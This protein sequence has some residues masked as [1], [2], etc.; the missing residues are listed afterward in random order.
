MESKKVYAVALAGG[1]GAALWPLS[2]KRKPK[3]LLHCGHDTSLLEQTI[4]RISPLVPVENRW[5]ITTE[6]QLDSIEPVISSLVGNIIIEP[7]GRDTAAA[8]IHAA[9]VLEQHDSNTVVIFL[10]TDHY[11]PQVPKFLDFLSH[12]IDFAMHHEKITFLGLP[13]AYPAPEYGYI[14]YD[15]DSVDYP[16]RVTF[17]H[18]KPSMGLCAEYVAQGLLWNSGIVVSQ[19]RLFLEECKEV[20]PDIFEAVYAYLYQDGDY[21]GIPKLSAQKAFFEK[22]TESSVLPADFLWC[23]VGNLE[24]F[25]S[26]RSHS[27]DRSQVVSIDASDNLVDAQD[28]LVALVGV[29]NLC[30][31]QSDDVLLIVSRDQVD[32]IK[33]VLEV[34]KREQSEEY[35]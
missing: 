18:E 7:D 12:A 22:S 24:K 14:G 26:L 33:A 34:L 35:L 21:Y 6:D 11:I 23:D 3:E 31:V 27:S 16:A 9:L 13:A 17:F 4:A 15:F 2:R 1:Q 28:S 20:A 19:V 25:L 32:K 10:P 8:M 5:I 29:D 30:V